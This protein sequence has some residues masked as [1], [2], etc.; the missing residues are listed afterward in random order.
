MT[1]QSKSKLK[2]DSEVNKEMELFKKFLREHNVK[3]ANFIFYDD[4]VWS[5]KGHKIEY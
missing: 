5:Y 1:V 3:E 2:L 4:D